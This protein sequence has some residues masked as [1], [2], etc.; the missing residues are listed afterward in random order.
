MT[1]ALASAQLLPPTVTTS[2]VTR[3]RPQQTTLPMQASFGAHLAAP[4]W[5][6]IVGGAALG[7]LLL[8]LPGGLL[9]AAAGYF[10]TR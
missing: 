5:L 6:F 7:A 10:L 8:G 4:R 2:A 9:G 3:R 1:A